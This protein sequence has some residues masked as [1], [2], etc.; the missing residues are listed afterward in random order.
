MKA[1]DIRRA[2]EEKKSLDEIHQM[3]RDFEDKN[4]LDECKYD[5]SLLHIAATH[6]DF[7]AIDILLAAG[8]KAGV[9]HRYG[10]TLLHN[11]AELDCR[12]YKVP[13]G[14]VKESAFKLL[15]A[16]VSPLR[17]SDEDETCLHRACWRGNHEFV[18]ALVARGAKLDMTDKNGNTPLH[19]AC[20]YSG[21]AADSVKYALQNLERAQARA[22]EDSHQ[23]YQ[24]Q[25]ESA[26]ATYAK[27]KA[28][29]DGYFL[30]A[31]ALVEGG[32]D[33]DEKNN[34]GQTAL[35]MLNAGDR[36]GDKRIAAVIGGY[37]RDEGESGGTEGE[38]ALRLKSG[39][40][41]LHQAIGKGDHEAVRAVIALGADLN[42]LGDASV[43]HMMMENQPPLSLAI[44]ALDVELVKLLLESG[45]DPNFK[46]GDGKSPLVAFFHANTSGKAFEEGRPQNVLQ[47]MKEHGLDINGFIDDDLC[48]PLNMAAKNFDGSPGYNYYSLAGTMLE[49]MLEWGADVNLADAKGVTPL[50]HISA[51]S[52]RGA[53][54]IQISLLEAGA[55][56]D[57]RDILGNTPLMYAVNNSNKAT[58]KNMA[59]MLFAFGD[60]LLEAVNNDRR[61]ALEIAATQDNEP[62]V[63]YLISKM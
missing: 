58:A 57:A 3:Y 37:Y 41:T 15:D 18:E 51:S 42:E 40:M 31:K 6:A 50:M 2:Y 48:T 61:S 1:G 19:I 63:K 52:S 60:P 54:N 20:E 9:T 13:A 36:E 14:A 25:L 10:N 7:A 33:V 23:I 28:Q 32:V 39:G 47:L 30:A 16:K 62:L 46:D 59:D 55:A 17:K 43:K 22:A 35:D 38:A 4:T 8:A 49:T 12:F 27:E 34:Y 21:R 26:K 29:F 24:E 11:L 53:E 44:A 56:I 5:E 45:A